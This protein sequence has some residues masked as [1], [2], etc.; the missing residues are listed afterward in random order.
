MMKMPKKRGFVKERIIRILLDNPG[1]NLTK[2]RVAKL[3]DAA[4]SWTHDFLKRLEDRGLITKT[5]VINYRE[6]VSLWRTLR[7]VPDKKEYMIQNPLELLKSSKLRYALTTYVAEN[8]TQKYLF[9]SRV[10]FY[11]DPKDKVKWHN[12][13][14]HEGLVGKG[15]TRVLIGD[16]HIFYNLAE[17]EGF[18]T[19]SIPQLV[20]DLLV[21][22][23]PCAEASEMLI[24]KEEEQFVHRR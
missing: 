22:G 14:S 9:P 19:V 20:V 5:R 1:G 12:I 8:L 16:P 3:A 24:E 18:K 7:I 17:K 11:I 21:E 4:Y 2:Y 23:G 10:D 6:L 13:L 15:N